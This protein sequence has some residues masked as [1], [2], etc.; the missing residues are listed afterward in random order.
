MGPP[1]GV[2][3]CI[4]IYREYMKK[5]LSETT[6]HRALIFGMCNHRSLKFDP[7]ITPIASKPKLTM[8][9][10]NDIMKFL[11]LGFRRD[12]RIELQAPVV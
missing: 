2:M 11:V 4:G 10:R 8:L 7:S 1:W 12:I 3:Y 6:R 5:S 9:L